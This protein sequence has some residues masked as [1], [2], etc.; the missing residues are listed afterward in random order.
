METRAGL[1]RLAPPG[2]PRKINVIKAQ[3]YSRLVREP[4]SNPASPLEPLPF[5]RVLLE[6]RRGFFLFTLAALALRLVFYFKFPHI[7]GDSLIYGDIAKNWLD[8][9]I[10]GLTHAEGVRPTWIRLPG[11][12]AFLAICFKLFGREHYHAVLLAQIAIDMAGCFVIADLARRTVSPEAAQF[13][14][15]LAAL[16]PFTANYT[17]APLAETL[18][19]FLAA[20]ALDAAVAGFMAIDKGSPSW[21]AWGLCGVALSGGIQMRPDGGILLAAIG[22]F[23]LWRLWK[24]PDRRLQLFWVGTLVLIIAIAPLVPWTLRNWS[25]FHQ[26]QPLAPR[27]ASDPDEFVP[28]GLDRWVRTWIVDYAS[29]EEVYWQVPG[30]D[31]DLGLLPSRAFDSEEERQRTQQI[32]DDYAQSH[33]V[34]PEL[35]E[36]FDQLGRARIRRN[37]LRYYV[38]LPALRI[39]DMWLRPRTEMLPLNSRWWEYADDTQDCVLATLW[40]TLNLLFVYAAV[41]GAIRGP[42]PRYLA[43]MLLF[44]LLRSA[45]LGTMENPEPRYTLECY[46]VVLV[47]GGAWISGWKRWVRA[48]L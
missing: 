39:A 34:G 42:R 43:M 36:R 40:G 16:C 10:Y 18:S 7:T 14:F 15:A 33:F 12:P 2:F 9:G 27:Y 1:Q 26:F 6:Y 24:S 8:H 19:I 29:T 44:V 45:F 37:P 20:V 21:K 35:N 17:V 32:F 11:Y 38:W 47:L 28:N 22:L 25:D 48:E 23:I 46:P 31:V 3:C 13:A 30:A 41:M 4:E 5:W